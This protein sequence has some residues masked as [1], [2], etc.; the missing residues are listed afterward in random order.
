MAAEHLRAQ[1]LYASP[2]EQL[3]TY[4]YILNRLSA[5]QLSVVCSKF[6]QS[7]LLVPALR[8]GLSPSAPPPSGIQLDSALALRYAGQMCSLSI[9]H[10]MFGVQGLAAFVATAKQVT[11]INCMCTSILEA[12]QAGFLLGQC[13]A[14]TALSLSGDHMPAALP[15]TVTELYASFSAPSNTTQPDALIY[16]AALLPQLRKLELR[17]SSEGQAAA[18]SLQAPVQLPFLQCLDISGIRLSAPQIDLKWVQQQPCGKL[19][20]DIIADTSDT[21]KHAAAVNHFSHMTL[22]CL[23][24]DM[25]VTFTPELQALWSSL[26]IGHLTLIMWDAALAPLQMLPRYSELYYEFWPPDKSPVYISWQALASRAAN[27]LSSTDG[28]LHVMGAGKSAP[29]HLHQPW[30]LG[31]YASAVYGVPASQPAVGCKYHLQNDAARAAGWTPD[32]EW[33]Q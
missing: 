31:V 17:L 12:A 26:K 10:D 22:S 29:D 27:I 14:I 11:W 32:R 24:L 6:R 21:G 4:G 13:S 5:L 7:T 28:E 25:K 15:S 1:L 16:Y 2:D 30:Q 9:R 33:N 20:L 3:S 8:L 23:Y 18:V 19:D